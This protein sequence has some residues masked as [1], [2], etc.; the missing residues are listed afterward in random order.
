MTRVELKE[1]AKESLK[2]NWGESIKVYGIYLLIC[3]GVGLLEG[4]VGGV[5]N[6]SEQTASLVSDITTIILSAMFTLGLASFYLKIARNQDVNYKE[7]FSK[8]NMFLVTLVTI[9]LVAIYTTLW[10]LLLIIPGIIASISYSQVYFIMLDNP[11]IKA[12][13]AIK[14]SKEMM[15][16]HKMDYFVLNLSFIGWNILCLLTFGIGFLWLIPYMNVTT[17]NFYDSIK[18]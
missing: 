2:G 9:F 14:K 8:T 5:L 15:N 16:G 7:L 11:S 6:F 10:T 13:E 4:I 17:A 3:F 1:R 12:N 18:G